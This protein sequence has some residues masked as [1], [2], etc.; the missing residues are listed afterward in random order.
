M[1]PN[2]KTC[3]HFFPNYVF[4]IPV[5]PKTPIKLRSIAF[6]CSYRG[7]FGTRENNRAFFMGSDEKITCRNSQILDIID[8]LCEPPIIPLWRGIPQSCGTTCEIC[9]LWLIMAAAIPHFPNSSP[10]EL[11]SLP[12]MKSRLGNC[13]GRFRTPRANFTTSPL[14]LSLAAASL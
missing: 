6:L 14:S 3:H 13:Y 11:F 8:K 9:E 12:P 4:Q 7:I 2:T 5:S 10:I 1:S